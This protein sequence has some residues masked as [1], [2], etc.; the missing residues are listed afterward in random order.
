MKCLMCFPELYLTGPAY[1]RQDYLLAVKLTT[2]LISTRQDSLELSHPWDN[3]VLRLWQQSGRSSLGDYSYPDQFKEACVELFCWSSKPEDHSVC[4]HCN[5]VRAELSPSADAQW[6]AFSLKHKPWNCL[7]CTVPAAV[8][9]KNGGF[10]CPY[11]RKGDRVN[12]LP[13]L[14]GVEMVSLFLEGGKHTYA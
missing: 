3:M 6:P 11:L 9:P 1:W 10:I 4:K 2:Y 8:W 12:S 14:K 5:G 7:A 13:P